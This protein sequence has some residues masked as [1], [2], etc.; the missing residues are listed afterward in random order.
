V[1][2][3]D[4]PR[5]PKDNGRGVHWAAS[6]Y[7]WGKENWEFWRAQL[8]AMNIKWVKILDDGGGSALPLARAL[9]DIGIM[10]VVRFYRPQQNPGS[11]GAR[12]GLAVKKYV[13]IGAMYFETNNE[14]DLDLEWR[15]G[16]KPD[17]WLDVVVYDWINDAEIV[18]GAGG[19]PGFPAF[20]VGT[21]RNPFARIAALG[22]ADLFERGAWVALH[23]YCLARPL[24]YPNDP[25]NLY[26]LPIDEE[27]WRAAGGMWAWEMSPEQVNAARLQYKNLQASIL[28]DSTCFRAF[29]QLSALIVAAFGHNVPILTT[30]G[31]YNVGQRGGTTAG[32]DARY[33]KPTP[34]AASNLTMDL[35]RFMDGSTPLLGDTVPEYYFAV[36]PWLVAAYQI[37]VFSAP[38]ESQGPWFTNSFD[39]DFGLAGELPLVAMLKDTKPRV[40][41]DGPAPVQ[42]V[43]PVWE[44]E[45]GRAWDPRLKYMDVQLGRLATGSADLYWKLVSAQWFDED[46]TQ[47]PGSPLAGYV[48]VR[49]IDQ[50]GDEIGDASFTVTRVGAVDRVVT[51]G[52]QDGYWGDYALNAKLG[53]YSVQITHGGHPSESVMGIGLG[54]ADRPEVW[55]R[56]AFRLIFQLTGERQAAPMMDFPD[57]RARF[58]AHPGQNDAAAFGITVD[59]RPNAHYRVRGVH[60][61]T[62]EENNHEHHFF[63]DV[64]DEQGRRLFGATIN[65]E[66]EGMQNYQRPPGVRVEKLP[67]TDAGANIPVN[68]GQKITAWV[69]DGVSDIVRGFHTYWPKTGDGDSEGHHSVY[70]LWQRVTDGEPEP[71]PVPPVVVPVPTD[72]QILIALKALEVNLAD[73]HIQIMELDDKAAVCLLAVQEEIKKLAP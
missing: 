18:L 4:Y 68:I 58:L 71:I 39:K 44:H 47:L 26:G 70:V 53:T 19:L 21:L 14:P 51:K 60:W 40:R 11:I 37:G 50:N 46:E 32:D 48:F 54:D 69:L 52:K 5:P 2:L 33:P 66:W 55:T 49:A 1:N 3:K 23:N 62:A 72:A 31:G 22:R 56:T 45:L 73:L 15:N 65:Y 57:F 38:E 28:T 16:K 30:E 64:V 12:G 42:W 61:L 35:F 6:S 43:R 13:D 8:L 10:P 7:S 34:Q 9:V 27:A 29:E 24:E 36:M 67:L 25:V 59:P 41:Q 63:A 17:N 20:G